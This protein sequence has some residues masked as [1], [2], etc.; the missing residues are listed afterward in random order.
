MNSSDCLYIVPTP[1]M[2]ESVKKIF[3]EEK[4]DLHVEYGILDSG[5]ALARQY[6]KKGVTAVA[7]RGKTSHVIAEACPEL[8][9]VEIPITGFDLL[10][11]IGQAKTVGNKVAV[12]AFQSMVLGIE[13]V[14]EMMNIQI[15]FFYIDEKEEIETV[16]A[17]AVKEGYH[18][19][20]G[21]TLTLMAAQKMNVPA[22]YIGSSRESILQTA[23]ELLRVA[24]VIRKEKYKRK[25]LSAIVDYA[26]DGIITVDNKGIITSINPKAKSI[27]RLSDVVGSNIE[28]IITDTQVRDIMKSPKAEFNKTITL[29]GI[30]IYCTKLPILMNGKVSGAVINFQ[31]ITKIQ[32][33]EASIRKEV[34]AKGHVAHMNFED[35]LG[36]SPAITS[37]VAMAKKYAQTESNIL[38]LGKTGTGKEVFAQ[39]IHNYSKRKNGPF[40]A[41]NCAALPSDL[42]ESELFGYVKGAFT[43][44]N[45]E[46]RVGLF[47]L[48]HKGTIFLDEIAELDYINQARLL[49]VLQ[50]RSIVRLGSDTVTHVDVRILAATNKD[51]HIAVAEKRFRDDL[52]YR[53]NVLAL[54]IP[55]LTE[56]KADIAVYANYFLEHYQGDGP[57]KSFSEEALRLLEEYSW[58]GNIRQ[59]QNVIQRILALSD[60][61]SITRATA[62]YCL[63]AISIEAAAPTSEMEELTTS[64]KR[65]I[66]EALREAHGSRTKAAEILGIDRSTLWRKMQKFGLT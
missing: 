47:E 17:K 40:V 10:Y 13:L 58:P 66:M 5:I 55:G 51:L 38:I 49:R 1:A 42:L 62:E 41:V 3:Q 36:K 20:L 24:Q 18:V 61:F 23:Q 11:A 33:I 35:I 50:E 48:A 52:Y 56:R 44:A 8:S 37:T 4:L 16:I 14:A 54:H 53:L 2:V 63:D 43:G 12:V 57:K 26:S 22:A 60:G 59:L 46:G 6:A 31:E 29:N 21:G 64:S 30:K 27:A 7:A 39:S 45:K 28:N 65:E 15:G 25:E 34:Y 32:Q 9:V 19:V